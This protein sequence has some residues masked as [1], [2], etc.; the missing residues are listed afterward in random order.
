[1]A[2]KT[3]AEY[4]TKLATG[5]FIGAYCLTTRRRQDANAGKTNAR[6]SEDGKYYILNGQ[7]MW[8]TNAGFADLQ[9]FFAK[10]G[11]DRF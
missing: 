5:E 3:T 9:R 2:M 11:N 10:I 4:V 8:I 7:K 1:M 6:L